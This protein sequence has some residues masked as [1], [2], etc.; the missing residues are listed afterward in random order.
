MH[1][2]SIF[3]SISPAKQQHGYPNT[4][5]MLSLSSLARRSSTRKELFLYQIETVCLPLLWFIC[6][7]SPPKEVPNTRWSKTVTEKGRNVT[8][9]LVRRWEGGAEMRRDSSALKSEHILLLQRGQAQ[10]IPELDV[11][12]WPALACICPPRTHTHTLKYNNSF[13]KENTSKYLPQ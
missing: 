11:F 3:Q 2:F 8:W 1:T 7:V 4:H 10:I 12:F 5:W 9:T 6:F 13:K